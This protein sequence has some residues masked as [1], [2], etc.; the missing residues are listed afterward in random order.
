MLLK[1]LSVRCKRGEGRPFINNDARTG[2]GIVDIRGRCS[3]F[4]VLL[5]SA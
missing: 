2:P 5:Y 4:I 1:I 3:R